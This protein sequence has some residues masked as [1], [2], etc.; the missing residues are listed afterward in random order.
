M[1]FRFEC[2]YLKPT[3]SI[4]ID[5]KEKIIKA[6]WLQLA[7]LHQFRKG[8]RETLQMNLLILRDTNGVYKFLIPNKYF[9]VT[10]DF[11]I[12]SFAIDYSDQAR[13]SVLVKRQ[14]F[15][16]GMSI[17]LSVM[18]TLCHWV[19]SLTLFLVHHSFLLL[20]LTTLLKFNSQ[21]NAAYR[22]AQPVL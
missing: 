21:T 16:V 22:T 8:F 14:S 6:I 11:F 3:R 9:E 5:D 15:S 7:E 4:S 10:A 2:G 13:I 12:N 20:D 17:S 1:E 18:E 19:M